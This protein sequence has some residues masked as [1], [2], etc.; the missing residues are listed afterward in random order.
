MVTLR[1]MLYGFQNH[2]AIAK[3]NHRTIKKNLL[4]S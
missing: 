3:R 4:I 2:L 1:L